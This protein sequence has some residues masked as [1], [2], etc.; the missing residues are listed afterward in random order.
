MTEMI[1]M[2]EYSI[3]ELNKILSALGEERNPLY[4]KVRQDLFCKTRGIKND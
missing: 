3:D 4:Y 1:M 2:S